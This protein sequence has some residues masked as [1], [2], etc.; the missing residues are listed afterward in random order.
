[1]IAGVR[2]E[3]AAGAASGLVGGILFALAMREQGLATEVTGLAGF[4]ASVGGVIAHLLLAVAGGAGFAALFRHQPESYATMIALGVV[5]GLLL[6]ILG[7]LTLRPLLDGNE[8]TWASAAAAEAFPSLIGHLVY[9]TTT[10]LGFYLVLVAVRY[11][12]PVEEV[13]AT[14]VAAPR[15]VVILGGGF[16]GLSAAQRLEQLYR[17]NA[18]L[19]VTL[20]SRSNYLLFTPMLAEVASSALE[21]QHISASMRAACPATRFRNATVEAIDTDARVV[22][23]RPSASG[24]GL[25]LP[26]DQL[27]LA[28]GSEPSFFGLP[29]L[30]EHAFTLKTLDD[31]TRLRNQV[32]RSLELADAEPD[33]EEWR[34]RLTFVVAGGGFAGTETIAELFDLVRSVQRYYP[35]LDRGEMRFALVHSGDRILPELSEGLSVYAQ[36]KLEKRGIQFLLGARVAGATAGAVQLNDG[37]EVQTRTLVWTAG[38]RPN[39]QL[40]ELDCEL[41]TGGQ[42]IV[43]GSLRVPGL[44]GV[45]AVGDCAQV[46]DPS[47]EGQ[48][49]PPTAQHALREGKATAENI[50]AVLRGEEPRPFR[51]ETIGSLVALGRRT[52][53]AEIR[54]RQFSGLLAWMMWRSVYISK[55]PGLEKKTRVALDWTIEL[56]FPRDIVLTSDAADRGARPAENDPA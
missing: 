3:L 21:A 24:P 4:E 29:G 11:V 39:P 42:V 48:F 56:F 28:L 32:L 6:W 47:T 27:V 37:R 22:Q 41:T 38:N 5:Y 25:A 18:D 53:A 45:W 2:L 10:A 30:E 51:F 19:E 31:A 40:M 52:A 26:Y 20:V 50:A 12:A 46:A 36:E 16:G 8:P 13:A 14:P 34:R 43:D 7:T 33:P 44:E 55:L 15:R 35:D 23:V 1:M 49:Y 9:A 17:G 54:G